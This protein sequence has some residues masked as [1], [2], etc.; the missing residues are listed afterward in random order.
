MIYKIDELN[1][2]ID[3]LRKISAYDDKDFAP[4]YLKNSKLC[5]AEELFERLEE[6]IV[7][8]LNRDSE[9]ELQV[10]KTLDKVIA[11]TFHQEVEYEHQ[12]LIDIWKIPRGSPPA[13][14]NSVLELF[15]GGE[16]FEEIMTVSDKDFK[17]AFYRIIDEDSPLAV[18]YGNTYLSIWI[19]N[20]SFI[21]EKELAGLKAIMQY[22]ANRSYNVE[23]AILFEPHGKNINPHPVKY[24][25]K[26]IF[27][28]KGYGWLIETFNL[29]IYRP[30]YMEELL[31]ETDYG[32]I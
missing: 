13:G 1:K 8:Y 20:L 17:A 5:K 18:K 23:W 31:D 7:A 25:A 30:S 10:N 21:A 3:Y 4:N 32:I 27:V 16:V 24:F 29:N 14:Y 28:T 11:D 6:A 2:R 19:K 9:F 22:C 12:E 26:D 15:K